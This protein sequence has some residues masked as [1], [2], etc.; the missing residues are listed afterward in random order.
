MSTLTKICVVL[1]VVLAMFA[2]VVFIQHASAKMKWRE[3][4]NQQ[5]RRANLAETQVRYLRHTSD[6]W[7]RLYEEAV[8]TIDNDKESYEI[9]LIGKMSMISQLSGQ[10]AELQ[11]RLS[12]VVALNS[13]LQGTIDAQIGQ[14]KSLMAQLEGVRGENITLADQLRGTQDKIKEYSISLESSKKNAEFLQEQLTIKEGEVDELTRRVKDL[15]RELKIRRLD[16][17]MGVAGAVTM[18]IDKIDGEVLAVQGELASLNVGRASGVKKDMEFKIYRDAD[19]IAHLRIADV[20]T[21]TCAGL[22]QNRVGEVKK[23]DKATTKLDTE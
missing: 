23:G 14:T 15:S 17:D 7:H 21:S 4:A 19:F 9:A 22:I 18:G 2:S 10:V 11:G 6:N 5:K 13:A 3:H 1:L 20:Y 12:E 8:K 16:G